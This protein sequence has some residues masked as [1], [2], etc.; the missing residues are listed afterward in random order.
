M[1]MVSF[2]FFITWCWFSKFGE[3]KE[4]RGQAYVLE[5]SRVRH[6]PFPLIEIGLE[7]LPEIDKNQS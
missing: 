7:Y 6:L 1:Y 5:G 4:F 2:S 3:D